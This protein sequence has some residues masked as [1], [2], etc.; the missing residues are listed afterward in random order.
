[1]PLD[2][3]VLRSRHHTAEAAPRLLCAVTPRLLMPLEKRGAL[4]IFYYAVIHALCAPYCCFHVAAITLRAS[5]RHAFSHAVI[6][7]F[8]CGAP[9]EMPQDVTDA[10]KPRRQ[11]RPQ[12]S[13]RVRCVRVRYCKAAIK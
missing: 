1:M 4:L 9:Q 7:D 2:A 3:H 13:P 10:V 6:E 12:I 5:C 11:V 8:A